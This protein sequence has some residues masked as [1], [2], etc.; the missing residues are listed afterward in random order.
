MET[1]IKHNTDAKK[2]QCNQPRSYA[3][4]KEKHQHAI[5]AH[6]QNGAAPPKTPWRSI[7]AAAVRINA[8][9]SCQATIHTHNQFSDMEKKKTHWIK[10]MPPTLRRP[11]RKWQ[12]P[13][14][15]ILNRKNISTT[16]FV[17]GL[18]GNKHYLPWALTF[19]RAPCQ[20]RPPEKQHRSFSAEP[21]ISLHQ[22]AVHMN[23]QLAGTVKIA[24]H[25]IL[26]TSRYR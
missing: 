23:S 22:V 14:N 6:P 17:A 26:R 4:E 25:Q 19:Q 11:P 9:H 24:D 15:T 3:A 20:P 13:S 5:S 18:L 7:Q 16:S 21:N 10:L 8:Q 1:P 12:H 2:Y